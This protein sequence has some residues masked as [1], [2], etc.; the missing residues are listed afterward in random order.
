MADIGLRRILSMY[1]NT[2]LHAANEV[3][4]NHSS[5]ISYFRL[6]GNSKALASAGV[7]N[8]LFRVNH[9]ECSLVTVHTALS[10]PVDLVNLSDCL[11]N[12]LCTF[13]DPSD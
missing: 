4:L 8:L 2:K 5:C 9:T 6:W 12:F 10:M 7:S 1:I 11:F 3:K 13:K